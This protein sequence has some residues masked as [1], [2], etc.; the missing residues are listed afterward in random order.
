[1]AQIGVRDISQGGLVQSADHAAAEQY[2][3]VFYERDGVVIG[4]CRARIE[5]LN[6]ATDCLEPV[7]LA[8]PGPGKFRRQAPRAGEGG[9]LLVRQRRVAAP[10]HVLQTGQAIVVAV[11][12]HSRKR[13]DGCRGLDAIEQLYS[14]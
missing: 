6:L 10:V 2:L 14:L 9:S 12:Y 8:R 11:R 1:M 4:M 5:E 3:R 13:P 7:L